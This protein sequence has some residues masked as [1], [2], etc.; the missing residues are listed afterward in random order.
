M[1]IFSIDLGS[2]SVKILESRLERKKLRHIQ[3]HEIP[4][5]QSSLPTAPP[6]EVKAHHHFDEKLLTS[7]LEVLQKFLES[8][9]KDMKF[10][11]QVPVELMSVRFKTIPVRNEK[12]ARQMIPFQLED[13]I[14]YA[15]SDIH[16]ASSVEKFGSEQHSTSLFVKKD[17]FKTY[18]EIL[19]KYHTIPTYLTHEV[20]A[21]ASLFKGLKEY[22][23]QLTTCVLDIGHMTTKAYFYKGAKLISYN[24]SYTAGNSI[25]EMIMAHYKV[26]RTS[27]VMFK[28]RNGFV[29]T[30]NQYDSV[31][32]KQKEFAIKMD[33]VLSKLVS[34]YK[35]WELTVRVNY[36]INID[37][38]LIT[39]GS[40][41]LKNI[42][43]YLAQN[44]EN[45]VEHLRDL[46]ESFYYSS[47]SESENKYFY[48]ADLMAYTLLYKESAINLLQGDFAGKN[49]TQLPLYS[50][51]F[52]G[53]R[54]AMI[55]LFLFLGLGIQYFLLTFS[56][57]AINKKAR[58]VLEN[59]ILNL[60]P[61][62]KNKLAQ[63]PGEVVKAIVKKESDLRQE[64]K[65]LT[66][67]QQVDALAGL[68]LLSLKLRGT[69]CKLLD[70]S[71][72]DFQE[73]TASFG[74]C[75]ASDRNNLENQVKGSNFNQINIDK[76]A[77]N[78]NI[79]F[80]L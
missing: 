21:Y 4:L 66:N 30:K 29:L 58:S 80:N 32:S 33:E 31:D 1:I 35:R 59:P 36:H 18:Y 23:S 56:N 20:S 53:V 24:I 68:H 50:I 28:H 52:V 46:H 12:K 45:K 48:T 55:S 14:P 70:Y 5:P 73:V 74:V 19:K 39:G 76:D 11:F 71:A 27:A 51:S 2:Y 60:S 8:V 77:Q 6:D 22:P 43:N 37:Q 47:L 67:L 63:N 69:P 57:E 42:E 79:K 25:D 49:S 7:Q 64:V 61:I 13:D 9:P 54:V 44:I 65:S 3:H 26:D 34:D 62:Y 78:L 75:N 17:L 10:T 40:S 16:L 15:L 41:R 72:N 38:V